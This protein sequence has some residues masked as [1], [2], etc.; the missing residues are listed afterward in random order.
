LPQAEIGPEELAAVEAQAET[1]LAILDYLGDT[2]DVEGQVLTLDEAMEL[3]LAN[4]P[5]L[6]ALTLE[7][8]AQLAGVLQARIKPSPELDIS[9]SEFLGMNERRYFRR[10]VSEVTY[11]RTVERLEKRL[12]RMRVARAGSEVARWD[13]EVALRNIQHAVARAYVEVLAAQENARVQG[14]LLNLA[15]GLRGAVAL[16]FEAG[17]VSELELSRLDIEVS[18]ARIDREQSLSE[19]DAARKRLSALWGDLTPDFEAVAGRIDSSVAA[20]EIEELLAFIPD[21]PFLARYASEALQRQSRLELAL[22]E[23]RSDYTVRGGVQGFGDSG[24]MALTLGITIPTKGSGLNP[25][26]VREAELR[27]EQIE[28]QR[29]ATYLQ[30][31]TQLVDAVTRLRTAQRRAVAL[32]EEVIPA[33]IDNLNR[34]TIGYRYGKFSYLD[35]LESERTL[36]ESVGSYIETLALYQLARVD[37]ERII[38]RPLPAE[39]AEAHVE[40]IENTKSAEQAETNLEVESDSQEVEGD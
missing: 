3:A 8:D 34:T 27:L 30:L 16:R 12:A 18:N 9:L 20:P 17:T 21:N 28:S 10:S 2:A 25:G 22:A 23:S 5:E 29:E 1:C 39:T 13:Y 32:C 15:E 7:I 4:N 6:V 33:A 14:L 19:L 36:V 11:S 38:G 24:E 35:V 37:V 31:Q 26:E 40:T